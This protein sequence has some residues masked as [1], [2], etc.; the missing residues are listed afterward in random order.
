MLVLLSW[1]KQ[2]GRYSYRR[3]KA[4]PNQEGL[5]ANQKRVDEN[6]KKRGPEGKTKEAKAGKALVK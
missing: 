1:Q 5:K 2:Y 4:L 3:I 6:I